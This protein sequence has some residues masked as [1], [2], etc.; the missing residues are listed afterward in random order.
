MRVRVKGENAKANASV[1]LSRNGSE[2]ES[3]KRACASEW[4][5]GRADDDISHP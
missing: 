3:T 4:W 2:S 5:R 1:I